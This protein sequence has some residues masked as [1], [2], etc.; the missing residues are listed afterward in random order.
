M[1][2]V[3]PVGGAGTRLRPHT[4]TLPKVL[5]N[6]A[7]KPILA[8]ILDAIKEQGINKATIVTGYMGKMV[9]EYVKSRYD[10]QVEFVLQEERKGLGHAIWVANETFDDDPLMIILGD[11]V[12]D[13]DL[14][15][16]Y[17]SGT[18]SIGIKE[19]ED[20]RRFG[21]VVTNKEN[22]ITKFVEKP[23]EPIS[24]KAIVGIYYISETQKFK[25]CLNELL[26][27]KIKTAGEYQLTDA[28]QLMLDKGSKFTTFQVEGWY[29]CGKP[30]TLLSTNRYLL[31]KSSSNCN[32]IHSD[33]IIIQPSFIAKTAVIARSVIGPYATVA[34]GATVTDSVVRDS[35]ISDGAI[36]ASSLL[37][38]SIIG[39]NAVVKGRFYTLNVGNSSEINY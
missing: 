5:L 26:T 4:Y 29:D 20:P 25:E 19:V 24:K 17:K 16:A 31:E 7:G 8:H 34:D 1:R 28:L 35:I 23:S 15:L 22:I 39:N 37:D 21:I 10:M 14:S 32:D 13:A 38:K 12:F 6:V 33:S 11:T 9:E 2:A 36:V 18:N 30:E 3:I 27:K